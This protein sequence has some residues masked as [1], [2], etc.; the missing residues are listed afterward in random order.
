MVSK[1]VCFS[2]LFLMLFS[3]VALSAHRTEVTL[4]T[5]PNRQVEIEV[6]DSGGN[7]VQS[8]S[9][10]SGDSGQVEVT[11]ISIATSL[12]INVQIIKIGKIILEKDY[13]PFTAGSPVQINA[14]I[15]P[16]EPEPELVTGEEVL[17]E[18]TTSETDAG[19]TGQA[20]AEDE[21]N[22]EADKP[23][24]FN[25]IY[26]IVAGFLAVTI[27]V[28]LGLKLAHSNKK[29]GPYAY[30]KFSDSDK[31]EPD[32]KEAPGK[33]EQR[34]RQAQSSEGDRIAKLEKTVREAQ[35]E[36]NKIKNQEKIKAVQKKLE[37]D[38]K[39]L[40]KLEKGEE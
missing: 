23:F 28:F 20:I 24:S 26:Y 12:N 34:E 17:I 37:E 8:F 29:K 19:V 21:G 15:A 36:L 6:T 31:E 11:C 22:E 25:I 38:R 33:E 35:I 9:K 27:L 1:T 5:E 4:K 7:P 40:E 18:E 39:A 14:E 2:I 13:G 32:K 16:E 3:V 10:T 30:L